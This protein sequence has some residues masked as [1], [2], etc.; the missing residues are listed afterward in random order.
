MLSLTP[1]HAVDEKSSFELVNFERA[2]SIRIRR[3]Q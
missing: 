2:P 1:V 3:F